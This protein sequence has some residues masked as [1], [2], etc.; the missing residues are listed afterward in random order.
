[1]HFLYN[2]RVDLQEKYAN[3]QEMLRR[4]FAEE[5]ERAEQMS[6]G[7]REEV[8]ILIFFLVQIELICK[9]KGTL[10]QKMCKY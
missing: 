2:E 3:D 7:K 6:H 10:S 4:T 9:L 8:Q 1:M 5:Y